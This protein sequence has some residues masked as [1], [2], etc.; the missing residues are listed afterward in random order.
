MK[1]M[2]HFAAIA[3]LMLALPS[4]S[5]FEGWGDI[6]EDPQFIEATEA[7]DAATEKAMRL[8]TELDMLR[9]Q[10]DEVKAVAER[11][12]L[13]LE[14]AQA[15]AAALADLAEIISD[16]EGTLEGIKDDVAEFTGAAEAIAEKY[17]KPEWMTT[18][19]AGGAFAVGKVLGMGVPTSGPLAPFLAWLAPILQ[20]FGLRNGDK[21]QRKRDAIDKVQAQKSK[22]KA[23]EKLEDAN[24][25]LGE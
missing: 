9:E 1:T 19:V 5:L 13:S 10:Y 15:S 24:A 18:A 14:V 23:L 3:L 21:R 25:I 7:A 12:G 11:D 6:L 20:A 8:A 16:K 17:D 22:V 4:C 2:K